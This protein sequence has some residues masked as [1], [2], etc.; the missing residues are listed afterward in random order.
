M[1]KLILYIA[2]SVDGFIAK[3]E[4]DLSF[5]SIVAKEGEDYGYQAFVESV[6]SVILGRRTYDWVNKNATYPHQ[7]KQTYVLTRQTKAKEGNITFYDG[8]LSELVSELKKVTDRQKADKN[9]FCDGGAQVV[10]ALLAQNLID[11]LIISIVPILVGNGIK[12]FEQ[13]RPEMRLTLVDVKKFDTGL[14]QL[15]YKKY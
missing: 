9:I 1:R 12:L 6:D 14:V 3:P 5:L 7:D 13:E 15:H 4:D 2:T 10:A 8:S 11:E